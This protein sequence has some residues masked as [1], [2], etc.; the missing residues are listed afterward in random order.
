M[1]SRTEGSGVQNLF[2]LKKSKIC[3]KSKVHFFIYVIIFRD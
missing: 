1:R 2:I 3:K